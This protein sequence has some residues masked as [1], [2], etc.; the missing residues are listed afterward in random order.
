MWACENN[1]FEDKKGQ[2]PSAPTFG[3][4][5]GTKTEYAHFMESNKEA[6]DSQ[7]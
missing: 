4:L 6:L 1:E 3:R 2:I 7:V 5:A